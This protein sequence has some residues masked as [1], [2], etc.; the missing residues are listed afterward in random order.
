VTESDAE[1]LDPGETVDLN[2]CDREPIH[3]PGAIQPHG[4]LL[5]MTE[6]ELVVRQCSANVAQLLGRPAEE[7]CG[8][9]LVAVVG[10]AGAGAVALL[11]ARPTDEDCRSPRRR[12]RA[13]TDRASSTS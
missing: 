5:T 13:P 9:P 1:L 4:L 6:P 10:D 3:I 7:V 12:L 8:A 11:A 2:T